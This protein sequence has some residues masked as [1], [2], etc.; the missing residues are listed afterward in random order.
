MLL[1]ISEFILVVEGSDR[2]LTW[3]QKW[4]RSNFGAAIMEKFLAPELIREGNLYDQWVCFKKEF[5]QFQLV[6]G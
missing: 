1:D 4:N 6:V 5:E 3:C 2:V